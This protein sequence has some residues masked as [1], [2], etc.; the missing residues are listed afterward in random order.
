MFKLVTVISKDFV[1]ELCLLLFWEW[2]YL[3]GRW[4]SLQDPNWVG[5]SKPNRGI[6]HQDGGESKP[7]RPCRKIPFMKERLNKSANCLETSF[8]FRRTKFYKAYYLGLKLYWS[9]ERVWGLAI[10]CLLG[11]RNIVL[12]YHFNL[13]DSLKNVYVNIASLS[14]L[15]AIEAK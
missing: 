9:W 3:S 6:W 10:S 7:G 4:E 2:Y 15:S 14:I 1:L 11:Y 8:F 12:P 5:D 13:E